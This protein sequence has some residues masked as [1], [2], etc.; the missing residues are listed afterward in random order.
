MTLLGYQEK[1]GPVGYEVKGQN[2]ICGLFLILNC[3]FTFPVFNFL[4]VIWGKLVLFYFFSQA[5]Y[6]E[7]NG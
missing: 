1:Y 5:F 6:K 2:A 7:W 3:L 4:T